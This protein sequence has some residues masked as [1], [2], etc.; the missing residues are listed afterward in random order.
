MSEAVQEP[1]FLKGWILLMS[2]KATYQELCDELVS[3]KNFKVRLT[4]FNGFGEGEV[5]KIVTV[6]Y[7]KI[8]SYE[9][10]LHKI[11]FETMNQYGFN[12]YEVRTVGLLRHAEAV[13]RK[14]EDRI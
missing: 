7:I 14:V 10:P 11:H 2:G 13:F 6:I 3:P 12:L 9:H 5:N 1:D 8:K 4:Q